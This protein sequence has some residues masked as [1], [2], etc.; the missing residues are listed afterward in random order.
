MGAGGRERAR[1]SLGPALG[2][3]LASIATSATAAAPAR[4]L[5]VAP[6]A[7][8][9][10]GNDDPTPRALGLER[11]LHDALG[12]GEPERAVT[13]AMRAIPGRPCRD[14]RCLRE[15]GRQVGARR[16]LTAKVV[17]IGSRC[18][19]EL[20]ILELPTGRREAAAVG[21][22]LCTRAGLEGTL[23]ATLDGLRGEPALR[24]ALR[25]PR[26]DPAR[27]PQP[28]F[29]VELGRVE[30]AHGAATL[31]GPRHEAWLARAKDPPPAPAPAASGTPAWVARG[32]SVVGDGGRVRGVAGVGLGDPRLRPLLARARATAEACQLAGAQRIGFAPRRDRTEEEDVDEDA[33]TETDPDEAE[34]APITACWRMSARPGPLWTS[35]EGV[36]FARV[37]AGSDVDAKDAPQAFDP[38]LLSPAALATLPPDAA[39][40]ERLVGWLRHGTAIRSED[41]GGRARLAALA[42]GL[43]LLSD[44]VADAE[45]LEEWQAAY[46]LET[47]LAAGVC[48]RR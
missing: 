5:V 43:L 35:A 47:L 22:G 4:G 18:R 37:E 14:D 29:A 9:R 13:A 27:A 10:I 36:V 16:L 19:V 41:D 21:K 17:R 25:P 34:D 48:R 2:L 6:I 20:R 42:E 39:L 15:R 12:D 30:L 33:P 32:T 28:D 38:R 23:A 1:R 31:P 8:G 24:S 45:R 46:D 26:V 40:C 11:Q 44:L 3:W 7:L